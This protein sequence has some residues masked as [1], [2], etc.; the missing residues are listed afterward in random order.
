MISR[1]RLL[2]ATTSLLAGPALA[3]D[4]GDTAGWITYERRLRG[5]LADAGGGRFD[6]PM[7]RELLTLTNAARIAVGAAAC[8]WNGELATVARAH[9]A[10]L[11]SRSYVEHLTPEGF[12]PGH[13]LGLIARTLIGSASENIAYRRHHLPAKASDLMTTWRA[14]APHWTN[15]LRLSHTDIGLGVAIRGERT[16]AVGL[17]ARPDGA[18]ATALPFRV[19]DERELAA[20]IHTA[21]PP[22]DGFSLTDPVDEERPIDWTRTP[23]LKLAPGVYQLRPRRRIDARRHAILW[24][25]IFLRT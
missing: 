23:V 14:S 19:G 20:V 1:R 11:A 7:A 3:L 16:Y 12:D 15:L 6:E 8:R 4:A 2:G 10:D 21:S 24:G 13:R 5:R 22:L 18:L 25:P 9:A 17:Y